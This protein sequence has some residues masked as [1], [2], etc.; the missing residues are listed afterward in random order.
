MCGQGRLAALARLPDQARDPR[1][2]LARHQHAAAY[3][4]TFSKNLQMEV[5]RIPLTHDFRN[6]ADAGRRLAEQHVGYVE[7]EAG[8]SGG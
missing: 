8:H 5:P 2:P 7:V 6:N 3:R 4:E 1:R